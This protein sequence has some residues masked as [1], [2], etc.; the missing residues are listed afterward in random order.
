MHYYCINP[1]LGGFFYLQF[2]IL[3]KEGAFKDVYMHRGVQTHNKY[4][5]IRGQEMIARNQDN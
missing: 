1:F 5:K 2:E 4:L 3:C